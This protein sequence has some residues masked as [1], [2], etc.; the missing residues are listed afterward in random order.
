MTNVQFCLDFDAPVPAA[1]CGAP[2]ARRR[3]LDTA[4]E[5]RTYWKVGMVASLPLFST[6]LGSQQRYTMMLPGVVEAIKG[7]L[8]NVRIYAAPEYGYTLENYP[9]HLKLAIDV[10]LRDLCRYHGNADL[11]RLA[12]E[13]RLAAG[14]A[15]LAAEV[16]ARNA[17]LAPARELEIATALS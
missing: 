14:D 8:A 13:G 5:A 17:E 1:P 11:Q 16:R 12:D 6:V 4:A 15:E 2:V 7:D 3:T 10:P 9:L